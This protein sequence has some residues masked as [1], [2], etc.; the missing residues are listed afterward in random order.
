MLRKY[1]ILYATGPGRY[2]IHDIIR[3]V[4]YVSWCIMYLGDWWEPTYAM[5]YFIQQVIRNIRVHM[6]N[7]PILHKKWYMACDRRHRFSRILY[8]TLNV[9]CFVCNMLCKKL[10]THTLLCEKW[11]QLT[12]NCK[13]NVIKF[14]KMLL[15]LST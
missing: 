6:L 4:T 12:R 1:V 2:M 10:L 9:F 13:T 5:A 7:A 3:C 11:A 15:L 8:V 14:D